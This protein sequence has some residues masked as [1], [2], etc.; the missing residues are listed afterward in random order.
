LQTKN[1]ADQKTTLQPQ[2]RHL[3]HGPEVRAP[4]LVRE[5]R[6]ALVVHQRLV[7]AQAP[8]LRRGEVGGELGTD[9]DCGALDRSQ[10]L[11]SSGDLFLGCLGGEVAV[12]LHR[13]HLPKGPHG[14]AEH[15]EN[16][17]LLRRFVF[18]GK[19]A[20]PVVLH[21]PCARRL[22][23]RSRIRQTQTRRFLHRPQKRRLLQDERVVGF[24]EP[25][26]HFL[27]ALLPMRKF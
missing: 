10:H 11:F 2:K 5:E 12:A 9:R 7:H 6:R 17:P 21:L 4:L 18:E 19:V 3:E 24:G 25:R 20:I 13:R 26:L 1:F 16:V 8:L 14:R 23:E 22:C 27:V 15:V